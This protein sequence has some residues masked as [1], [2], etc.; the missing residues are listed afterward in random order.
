MKEEKNKQA[1]PM[2]PDE[3]REVLKKYF[4][5]HLKYVNISYVFGYMDVEVQ[6]E[7]FKPA[8]VV[9]DELEKILPYSRVDAQREISFASAMKVFTQAWEDCE[10]WNLFMN[11]KIQDV[12]LRM[13]V[14]TFLQDKDVYPSKICTYEKEDLK[15]IEG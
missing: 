9:R 13:A 4:H 10:Q 6:Y 1:K 8:R 3:V 2:N 7:D 5:G 11:G 15:W 12:S 14:Y